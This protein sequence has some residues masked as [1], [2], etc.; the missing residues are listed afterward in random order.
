ML[1]GIWCVWRV[2]VC[3]YDVVVGGRAVVC[4]KTFLNQ[5]TLS[6]LMTKYQQHSRVKSDSKQWCPL[7]CSGRALGNKTAQRT[8]GFTQGSGRKQLSP[9]YMIY[10]CIIK[11]PEDFFLINTRNKYL[12]NT[13]AIHTEA[14]PTLHCTEEANKQKI[15][16]GEIAQLFF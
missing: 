10:L 11:V 4:V 3:V 5:Q 7:P 15:Q 8:T 12:P 16:A 9:F 6:K 14:I 1:W 2:C 13:T